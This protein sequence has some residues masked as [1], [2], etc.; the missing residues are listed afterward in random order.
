[1]PFLDL[2]QSVSPHDQRQ[3]RIDDGADCLAAALVL[4]SRGLSVLAICPPDHAGVGKTHAEHCNS[5]GKCP[6]GV[7]KE[8]QDRLPTADEI[9]KKWRDNPTCNVGAALGPVSGI[10]RVDIEGNIAQAELEQLSGGDLPPTWEFKS[11]RVDGTGRGIL[12]G[13]PPGVV[14]QTTGVSLQDGELRFQ[15]KGAQTVLPPSRHMSGG[16]YAWLP[17]RSPSEI[18]IALAPKWAI[19]RYKVKPR[20]QRSRNQDDNPVAARVADALRHVPGADDYDS[21]LRIGMALHDWDLEAGFD[22]WCEWSKSSTK[23]DADACG[24]KWESFSA[25]DGVTIASVFGAARD[26]GWKLPPVLGKSIS[27]VQAGA[28][29]ASN[30][31][32]PVSAQAI[33][34]DYFRARYRPVY[35]RGNI[36]CCVDGAEVSMT[37]ACSVADSVL[38]D[39]LMKAADVPT[40][41]G[42]VIKRNALPGF[43]KTWARVAWGDLLS[44]LPDEDGVALES[45]GPAREVFRRLMREALL[46]EVVLGD[47]IGTEGT[48]K[49]ERRSL[50]DWCQRFAKQ[51]PWKS[52]RSKKCWC[53]LQVQ[54]DGELILMVA[55]RHEL[56]AQLRADKRLCEIGANIFTRR[57]TRYGVGTS[58][59]ANRP[60]GQA[61]VVLDQEFVADLTDS[62]HDPEAESNE[63]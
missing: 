52:I 43:F 12:W 39:Q 49:T 50:I 35:R 41:Q 23:F 36:I 26:A 17:G 9:R 14:F 2:E 4:L 3:S 32:G 37:V 13:I 5:P 53:K 56:L 22:L 29:G 11:G 16:R 6:W 28:A 57:A 45:D 46:S 40:F 27:G 31:V 19:E 59:R 44:T 33:I 63:E 51:G 60:R 24:V 10:V 47:T 34:L 55:I 1:M 62:I 18:Q 15:A 54:P 21:W 7:W 42:G 30:D 48:T 8:F 20:N 58:T 61:V 25:G 38:I